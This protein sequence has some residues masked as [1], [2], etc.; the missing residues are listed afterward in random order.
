MKERDIGAFIVGVVLGVLST[1][2]VLVAASGFGHAGM[3]IVGCVVW[4]LITASLA[5][6]RII[7]LGLVPNLVTIL[8]LSFYFVFLSP[9]VREWSEKLYLVFVM[10]GAGVVLA[11][12]V[13]GTVYFLRRK[14]GKD[15]ETQ[16]LFSRD[17]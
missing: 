10:L 2:L 7:L 13:S 9:D 16:P 4:P 17:Q 3:F 5:S 1:Y 15:Q 11:L 6:R 14:L 8:C 12:L